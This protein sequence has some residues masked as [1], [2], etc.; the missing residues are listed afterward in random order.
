MKR[1][2][3]IRFSA[4]GRSD[5]KTW[6]SDVQIDGEGVDADEAEKDAIHKFKA[7]HGDVP[8][9][10][11]RNAPVTALHAK[12]RLIASAAPVEE[13]M[14]LR[15][16]HRLLARADEPMIAQPNCANIVQPNTPVQ[17]NKPNEPVAPNEPEAPL[18]PEEPITADTENPL[19]DGVAFDTLIDGEPDSAEPAVQRTT[20][21][22]GG[23]EEAPEQEL[24]NDD[25]VA[26][27]IKFG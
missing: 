16:A 13:P 12:S 9:T 7:E 26:P 27:S 21:D 10:V 1:T 14:Q 8:Y 11:D 22:D 24:L 5:P 2:I 25:I 15:A 23:V 18:M 19:D 3:T 20:K 17:P 4:S 6:E